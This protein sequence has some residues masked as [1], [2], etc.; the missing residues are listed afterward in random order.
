METKERGNCTVKEITLRKHLEICDLEIRMK[1][2]R[3]RIN[4]NGLTY[5]VYLHGVVLKQLGSIDI[6]WL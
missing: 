2:S 5:L 4:E 6:Y 3:G 1:Y